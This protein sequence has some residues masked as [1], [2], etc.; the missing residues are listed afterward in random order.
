M[1]QQLTGYF[2][3]QVGS[4]PWASLCEGDEL[5]VDNNT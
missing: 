5:S 1:D 2:G 3:A 4:Q